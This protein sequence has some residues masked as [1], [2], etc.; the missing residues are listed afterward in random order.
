MRLFDF[1]CGISGRQCGG[2]G[3]QTIK[4]PLIVEIKLR[5]NGGKVGGG[6]TKWMMGV[7]E[8]TFDEHWVLLC[9]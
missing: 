7:K 3:K 6:Q 8:G 2:R 4:R 5:V 9:R 1:R